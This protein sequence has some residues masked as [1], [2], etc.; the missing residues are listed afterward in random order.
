[1][2]SVVSVESAD[3]VSCSRAARMTLPR[4]GHLDLCRKP[5]QESSLR[6]KA[7]SLVRDE[8]GEKAGGGL[9]AAR[10]GRWDDRQQGKSR[11]FGRINGLDLELGKGIE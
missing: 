7:R 1:M 8:I 5:P 2:V 3:S 6:R 4:S 9:K 10:I 11:R